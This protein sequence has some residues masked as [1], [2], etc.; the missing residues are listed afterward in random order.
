M[1]R[2]NKGFSLVEIIVVLAILAIAGL[3]GISGLG[4]V[5]G[6]SVKSCA[7]ELKSSIGET[8]IN[9]M[10]KYETTI[11][12]YEGT[13]GFYKQ[14]FQWEVAGGTGSWVSENPQKVG[15][16]YLTL[17][18]RLE[19]GTVGNIDSDGIWISFNRSSGR[20]RVM[21]ATPSGTGVTG[22]FDRIIVNGSLTRTVIIV[23]ATG[24]IMVQ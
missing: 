1:R 6:Q 9:T 5:F 15:K 20:E 24:K 14:E 16:S 8:R 2:D 17:Q 18:Y 23:P 19:D 13:D 3:L 11:H 21:T 12:I 7:D 10:G 22:M 4:Y